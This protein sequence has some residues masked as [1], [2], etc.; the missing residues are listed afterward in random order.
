M[1][2]MLDLSEAPELDKLELELE[3]RLELERVVQPK[4]GEVEGE[5]E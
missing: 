1:V 4:L 2:Q 5:Q 3:L